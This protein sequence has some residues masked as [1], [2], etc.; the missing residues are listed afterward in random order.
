M[1]YN[2]KYYQT[3]SATR[4]CRAGTGDPRS[5]TASA[6][7]IIAQRDADRK[8]LVWA[9]SAAQSL[10]ECALTDPKAV[11]A[12][13]PTD[14]LVAS[15]YEGGPFSPTTKTYTL[16]NIGE[17]D[18]QW[19]VAG[20]A[21]VS[22][23]KSSG[24]LYV[25]ES[26]DITVTLDANALT[27][28]TYASP[29]T[30]EDTASGSTV[31]TTAAVEVMVVPVPA[32]S[33]SY[34]SQSGTATLI[35]FSEFVGHASSPPKKYLRLSNTGNHIIC[36]RD[37]ASCV[38][39]LILTDCYDYNVADIV[40]DPSTGLAN[41]VNFNEY[42]QTPGSC[43][44]S[45]AGGV[46]ASFAMTQRS[47]ATLAGATINITSTTY[48]RSGDGTCVTASPN[49]YYIGGSSTQTLSD[50]DTEDAAIARAAKTPGTSSTA[51]RPLRGAGV[52]TMLFCEVAYTLNVSGL[53][54]GKNYTVTLDLLTENYGGGGGVTTQRTYNFTTSGY[55]KTINDTLSA[56]DGKQVTASNPQVSLVP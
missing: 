8:A 53:A 32:V 17:A 36:Y 50:E 29:I 18:A 33:A 21:W 40:Y 46:A 51:F 41:T 13:S 1:P 4:R 22:F 20:P 39:P 42:T 28:G 16:T 49:Y 6:E 10:L 26:V 3:A 14:G 24:Y 35:G 43:S 45:T 54:P 48:Q 30:F 25:G 23:S 15:G 19:T 11:L 34:V 37:D 12:L 7:S 47:A 2:L 55:T 52:F 31:G 44:F 27:P 9:E 56:V 5:Y 38:A